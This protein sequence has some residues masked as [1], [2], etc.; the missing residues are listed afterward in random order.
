M[1]IKQATT[2]DLPRL[3]PLAVALVKS[4]NLPFRVG[5]TKAVEG[6]TNT[7]LRSPKGVLFIGETDGEAKTVIGWIGAFISDY[8]FSDEEFC[9]VRAWDVHP[10]YRNTGLG[11]RLLAEVIKWSKGKGVDLISVG[12]NIDSSE[13]PELAF[14]KLQ[15]AGFIEL[16]RFFVKRF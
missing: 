7:F 11:G 16:E 4:Q 2:E 15:S 3:A 10:D 8:V 14:G 5:G 12:V 13:T 9:H 1:N 6:F